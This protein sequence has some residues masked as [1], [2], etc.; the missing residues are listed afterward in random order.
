MHNNKQPI[1]YLPQNPPSPKTNHCKPTTNNNK[2][3]MDFTAY[4]IH[5]HENSLPLLGNR[6]KCPCLRESYPSDYLNL[7]P[8]V[9]SP[10][11]IL[12]HE[13]IRVSFWRVLFSF[14]GCHEMRIIGRTCPPFRGRRAVKSGGPGSRGSWFVASWGQGGTVWAFY[15][16]ESE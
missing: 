16:V 3:H 4:R 14:R 2:T 10:L 7:N 13:A 15:L 1:L 11:S 8:S 6:I 12:R 5:H 9:K